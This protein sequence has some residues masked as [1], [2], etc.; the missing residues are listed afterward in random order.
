MALGGGCELSLHAIIRARTP[1]P[2][3]MSKIDFGACFKDDHAPNN[4][5]SVPTFIAH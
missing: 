3:P 4:T 5:E 2:A 1:V